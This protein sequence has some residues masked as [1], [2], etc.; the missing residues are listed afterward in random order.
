MPFLQGAF[1]AREVPHASGAN[2]A[3]TRWKKLSDCGMVG[4]QAG[5]LNQR[6]NYTVAS[7]GLQPRT[8]WVNTLRPQIGQGL[9]TKRCHRMTIISAQRTSKIKPAQKGGWRS[10]SRLNETA[11]KTAANGHP[12]YR[13]SISRLLFRYRRSFSCSDDSGVGMVSATVRTSA[14]FSRSF[15]GDQLVMYRNET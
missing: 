12:R 10:S 4:Y 1:D 6:V 15:R 13:T 11:E 7:L 14:R 5:G 2:V 8:G 3:Q 9:L